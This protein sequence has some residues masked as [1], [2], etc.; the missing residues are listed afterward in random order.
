MVHASED[1]MRYEMDWDMHCDEHIYGVRTP[2]AEH[3][4][5]TSLFCMQ[6][7]LLGLSLASPPLLVCGKS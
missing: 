2:H 1:S 4:S 3:G 6:E 5:L 7:S